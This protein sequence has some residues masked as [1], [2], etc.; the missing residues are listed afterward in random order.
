MHISSITLFP[1]WFCVHSYLSENI[2]TVAIKR[3][4]LLIKSHVV[5][6][7]I[8]RAGSITRVGSALPLPVF[9]SAVNRYR[10]G[11]VQMSFLFGSFTSFDSTCNSPTRC[12]SPPWWSLQAGRRCRCERKNRPPG[13]CSLLYHQIPSQ[14]DTYSQRH[15]PCSSVEKIKFTE[16]KL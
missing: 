13:W 14:M 11:S 6:I 4:T 1:N 2:F 8:D 5:S 15:I 10:L 16:K 7:P 3:E 12:C 9:T